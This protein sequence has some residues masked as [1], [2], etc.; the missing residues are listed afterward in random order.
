MIEGSLKAPL[1]REDPGATAVKEVLMKGQM[2]VLIGLALLM[3]ATVQASAIAIGHLSFDVFIDTTNESP[4]VNAFNISDFSGTFDLPPD[5]P[6]STALTLTNATLIVDP[7]GGPPQV[8]SLGNIVPG[9]LLDPTDESPLPILQ[10]PSTLSFTS[11][12]LMA[13]LSPTTFVLS[14]G[15]L[16]V[17]DPVISVTLSP[18][19][20]SLL[21]PGDDALITARSA[22]VPEPETWM[23]FGTAALLRTLWRPPRNKRK[24]P[25]SFGGYR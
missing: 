21:V 11:A 6:A 16:F 14:N 10:F 12:G 1:I 2:P 18:S 9:P 13:T 20:G 24:T 25:P 5:F 8:I 7:T 3:S 17:A 22:A 4:G 19:S 23:L 15:D